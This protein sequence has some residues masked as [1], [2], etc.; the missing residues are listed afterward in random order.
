MKAYT[1]TDI[2][3][4]I[5][6]YYIEKSFRKAA[7]KVGIPKS[8]INEWVQRIGHKIVD[9]RKVSKKQNRKRKIHEAEIKTMVFNLFDDSARKSVL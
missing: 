4:A 1:I 3:N 5:K 6:T 9:K 8:T 2:K 7:S